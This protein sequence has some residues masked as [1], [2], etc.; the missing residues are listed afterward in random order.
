MYIF[1]TH[2]NHFFVGRKLLPHFH[3]SLQPVL[4]YFQTS[5]VTLVGVVEQNR[6][7]HRV[8]EGLP[9]PYSF[10]DKTIRVL[11]TFGNLTVQFKGQILTK[12]AGKITG[13]TLPSSLQDI[14]DETRRE[15]KV[16]RIFSPVLI[17][18]TF[19]W[20]CGF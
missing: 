7:R 4:A 9:F 17:N 1:F 11:Q 15:T 10:F 2:L 18:V 6:E 14:L 12:T 19:L 13:M 8:R 5:P 16:Q 20:F 3:N